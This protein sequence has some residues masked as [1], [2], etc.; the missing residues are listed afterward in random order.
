MLALSEIAWTP[1]QNKDYKNFSESRVPRHLQKLDAAGYNY[2]VPEPIG[3]MDT[4]LIGDKFTIELKPSVQGA[5]VH[6][7]VDGNAPG[8]TDRQ[9]TAPLTY[10]IPEGKQ[11]DFKSST[12]TPAGKRSVS[13]TT[14][15]KNIKEGSK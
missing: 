6:Y 14:K 7:T 13:V 12:I 10:A 9:Y 1:K 15:M 3:A 4:T 5:T 11:I 8:E 2:R